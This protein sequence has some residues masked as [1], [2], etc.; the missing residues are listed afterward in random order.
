MS[1]TY[2]SAYAND[3]FCEQVNEVRNLEFDINN[4]VWYM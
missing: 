2:C 4:F 1:T 3:Q